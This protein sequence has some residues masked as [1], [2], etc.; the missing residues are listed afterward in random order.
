MVCAFPRARD[1]A[2]HAQRPLHC[3]RVPDGLL[4]PSSR[5]QAPLRPA[6]KAVA[7]LLLPLRARALVLAVQHVGWQAGES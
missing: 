5:H 4:N 7:P 2:G 1:L 6:L 3:G